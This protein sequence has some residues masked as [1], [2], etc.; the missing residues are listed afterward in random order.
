MYINYQTK[1]PIYLQKKHS[2]GEIDSKLLLPLLSEVLGRDVS[3]DI[4]REAVSAFQLNETETKTNFCIAEF[5]IIV[6]RRRVED[7][8][9][10]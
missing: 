10:K 5:L 3:Q 7:K 4:L 9:H 6:V 1:F 2:T 8:L